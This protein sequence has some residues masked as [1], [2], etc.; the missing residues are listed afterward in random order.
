[1][2]RESVEDRELGPQNPESLGVAEPLGIER[3]PVI[4]GERLEIKDD[5]LEEK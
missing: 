1:V 2:V 4:S 5:R 3:R